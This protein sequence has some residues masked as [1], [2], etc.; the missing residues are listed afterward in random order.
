MDIWGLRH[1]FINSILLYGFKKQC[2]R[3]T[4]EREVK[5]MCFGKLLDASKCDFGCDKHSD[6]KG[7]MKN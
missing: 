4:T 2:Y 3:K 1:I 7:D 5:V 6:S